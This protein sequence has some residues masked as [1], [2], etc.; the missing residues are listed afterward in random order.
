[1]FI[2][3]AL[4]LPVI[5]LLLTSRYLTPVFNRKL[6]QLESGDKATKVSRSTGKTTI[7]YRVMETLFTRNTTERTSFQLAW[8]M[9]GYERL[10]KQSF[11]PSLAYV[12]IMIVAP[13]FKRESSV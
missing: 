2:V 7:Y 10:F 3:E 12:L 8:R 11:F 9:S 13:F 1:M 5:T 6:L 4:L